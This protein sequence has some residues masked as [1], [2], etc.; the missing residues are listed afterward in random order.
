MFVLIK[1]SRLDADTRIV[2]ETILNDRMRG[3]IPVDENGLPVTDKDLA[4][5]Y[6][7][8]LAAGRIAPENVINRGWSEMPDSKLKV[9]D[10]GQVK[11][12]PYRLVSISEPQGVNAQELGKWF[13]EYYPQDRGISAFEMDNDSIVFSSSDGTKV[14]L[15]FYTQVGD[16]WYF[17]ETITRQS[18]PTVRNIYKYRRGQQRFLTTVEE[19]A[20]EASKSWVSTATRQ[21]AQATKSK[22]GW[23]LTQ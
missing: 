21:T 2:E 20:K 18:Q 8:D 4:L 5:Q 14:T 16:S 11:G 1:W 12:T 13:S 9:W 6:G 22:K 19:L 15:S 10:Q 7:R 23:D 17:T 3:V